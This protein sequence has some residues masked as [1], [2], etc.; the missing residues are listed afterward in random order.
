MKKAPDKFPVGLQMVGWM[1]MEEMKGLAVI[2][3]RT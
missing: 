2:Y 3:V 1:A